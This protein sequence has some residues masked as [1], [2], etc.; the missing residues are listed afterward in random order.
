METGG[1]VILVVFICG[2]FTNAFGGFDYLA[3]TICTVVP[4]VTVLV[5]YLGLFSFKAILKVSVLALI[6]FGVFLIPG[7]VQ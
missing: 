1:F 4:V 6:I 2:G 7:V 5:T 3:R